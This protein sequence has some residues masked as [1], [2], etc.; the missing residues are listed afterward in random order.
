M[1]SAGYAKA[2]GREQDPIV[3]AS[4]HS[5]RDADDIRVTHPAFGKVRAARVSGTTNLF[6]VDYPQQ[7]YVT[8]EI[9]T[10]VLDR[11]LSRDWVHAQTEVIE[12]ALSEAQWAQLLTGMNTEGV[13]C[14]IQRLAAPKGFPMG[15]VPAIPP[16]ASEAEQHK[17][18]VAETARKVTEKTREAEARLR[19]LL[20]GS[21]SIRK[22]DL[23]EVL[24]L[25]SAGNRAATDSMP[26]VVGS[27]CEAIDENAV[28]GK[29]EV[30]AFL[31]H[32]TQQLG[33]RAVGAML[34]YEASQGR[35]PKA[36][37]IDYIAPK[38]PAI[39]DGDEGA[40]G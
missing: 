10:A 38:A 36:A 19:E 37:L 28:R 18:E 26:Y 29:S 17:A 31:A 32:A 16:R 22:G 8:L 12:I 20:S 25:L 40:R 13:E 39:E 35:D 34:A 6:G 3:S 9:K 1:R 24:G 11:G 14:T 21:G 5:F 27:A 7:H 4:P 33:E 15:M 23:N 30:N 2:Q